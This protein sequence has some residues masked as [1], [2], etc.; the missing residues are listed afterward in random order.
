MSKSIEQL[1][2]IKLVGL[3]V[4]TSNAYEMNQATAKIG[5]TMRRFFTERLQ[6]KIFYRK[7]PGRVFAVYTNYESDEHGEYTYFLGE[8][9]YS[10]ENI[11]QK[12]ATL[13]IPAQTYVKFTSNPGQMPDVVINMWKNIWKMNTYELGGQ[14]AYV[15][16]F[17]IYDERSQNPNNAV[18]DIYIGITK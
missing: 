11:E 1:S 12:Y 8:E 13:T 2:T 5:V 16:D 4:Q 6:D 15:A 17:E 9:V 7:N 14:R 10:F 3:K 18:C